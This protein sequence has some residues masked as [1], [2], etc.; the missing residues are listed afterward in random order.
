MEMKKNNDL[1][2]YKVVSYKRYEG[3]LVAQ[4]KNELEKEALEFFN[5]A[6]VSAQGGI[7]RH[8]FES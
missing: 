5:E 6:E 1:Q 4:R 2:D 7:L 8:Q 3:E